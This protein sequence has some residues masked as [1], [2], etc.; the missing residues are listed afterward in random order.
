[1]EGEK[2]PRCLILCLRVLGT[3]Q[4]LFPTAADELAEQCFDVTACYFPITFTPPPNDPFGITPEMLSQ[5]LRVT[6]T[7]RYVR[8]HGWIDISWLGLLAS[9]LP[10]AHASTSTSHRP[11]RSQTPVHPSVHASTP[12]HTFIHSNPH[13][14]AGRPWPR[15]CCRCWSGSSPPRTCPPRWR[16]S[17]RCS[18]RRGAFLHTCF[19]CLSEKRRVGKSSVLPDSLSVPVQ[20]ERG[21]LHEDHECISPFSKDNLKHT[22]NF[23]QGIRP[24][25]PPPTTAPHRRRALPRSVRLPRTRRGGPSPRD[26]ADSDGVPLLISAWGWGL[27]GRGGAGVGPKG[28]GGGEDQPGLHAGAVRAGTDWYDACRCTMPLP[29]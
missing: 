25:R 19:A 11:F 28:G 8:V 29:L 13:T 18:S 12:S 22:H 7:A 2:D 24:P 6:L 21:G 3:T 20:E 14:F 23:L 27:A 9:D 15:W 4:Q 17:P 10:F 1:M 26:G 16:P 5:A